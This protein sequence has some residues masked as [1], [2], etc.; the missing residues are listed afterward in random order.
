[1]S[2]LLAGPIVRR[3]ELQKAAI[4]VATKEPRVF[5]GAVFER[6][7]DGSLQ[8]LNV[9]AT[10]RTA[11]MG[12]HLFVHIIW[13]DWQDASYAEQIL[14]YD[15]IESGN[16]LLHAN[17]DFCY[18][19]EPYPSFI[20]PGELKNILHGSCRKPHAAA[21]HRDWGSR[22]QLATGAK[23][24]GDTIND[25]INRPSMLLMTGDQIYADDVGG[26]M[27][28]HLMGL[29]RAVTGWDETMPRRRLPMD[30]GYHT[31]N[32]AQ[33]VHEI[34]LY[35]RIPE[36]SWNLNGKHEGF[37]SGAADNHLMSFGEYAAMYMC[38]FGGQGAK[39]EFQDWQGVQHQFN[40]RISKKH[41]QKEKANL[42]TFAQ[43][44]PEVRRL[45]ANISVYMQCDDHE[46]TDDW[47]ISRDW[48]EQV[49]GKSP[50]TRRIVA[51]A[52]AA[53][54]A[55]QGWG[56]DPE[57][58][59]DGFIGLLEQ[60]LNAHRHDGDDAEQYD[61][62]LW[63]SKPGRWFFSTPTHP[64]VIAMDTRTCRKLYHQQ[65]AKLMHAE[66]LGELADEIKQAL[67]DCDSICLISPTPVFGF[68]FVE[69]VQGAALSLI[70]LIPGSL[71]ALDAESWVA[72]FRSLET[73][74]VEQSKLNYVTFLSGDVHYSFARTAMLGNRIP[75]VQL[76]S[77]PLHNTNPGI[78]ID[79]QSKLVQGYHFLASQERLKGKHVAV[80]GM[81]NIAQVWFD[82]GRAKKQQLKSTLADGTLQQLTYLIP[83]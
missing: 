8:A 60:H 18:P 12:E 29:G 53:Y 46:V 73:M 71:A 83:G 43:T 49:Q 30:G 32:D 5:S 59:S 1:M 52:L 67:N 23:V 40:H 55:F 64:A 58:F 2:E 81:N 11:R 21:V 15:L 3:T 17:D 47:N 76:T 10:Q 65:P 77:S 74:L 70:K 48:V 4:W 36:V 13:L 79:D 80:T 82:G 16:S 14:H 26:P 28:W 22:D 24:V 27:L 57:R 63:A 7:A 56:N 31:P 20:V 42:E 45:L 72:G 54:W 78:T 51:N 69:G 62:L 44:L 6:T 38:V 61:A 35:R 68:R 19:G 75:A 25:Q 33:K 66:A 50:R 34:E 41:Y 9:Q 39:P 37:S